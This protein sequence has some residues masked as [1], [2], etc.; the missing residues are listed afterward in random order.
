MGFKKAI[1]KV[2]PLSTQF[3]SVFIPNIQ[4]ND[5]IIFKCF[6]DTVYEEEFIGMIK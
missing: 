3:S 1:D 5:L 2:N 4:Y 6:G